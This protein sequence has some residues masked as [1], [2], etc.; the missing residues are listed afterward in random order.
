MSDQLGIIVDGHEDIASNWVNHDRHPAE[1]ALKCR[2]REMGTPI[3]A[4]VGHR[5]TGLAEW[6]AGRVALIFATL[7]VLPERHS[8]SPGI[9][10]AYSSPEE[11]E[12]KASIQLDKYRRLVDEEATFRLIATAGDLDEVLESW[13][14]PNASDALVGLVILMEGA[15]PIRQ[16]ADVESWYERGLRIVG[17]AWASTRYAGGS[18]EP[19]PL[20]PL[21]LE[22]LDHMAR[23]NMILDLSHASERA[24]LEALST[25]PSPVIASHSNPRAFRPGDR[26]LSDEMIGLLA[27][28]DGVM[29]IVPFNLFLT[30]EWQMGDPK[31]HVSVRRVAQA[32]D[33]VAQLT[34][35]SAHVALGTD[36]DGGFGAQS[37]PAEMDT[38]ADL[39]LIADELDLMGYTADDVARILSGNWLRVLRRGLE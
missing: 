9:P 20:T 33:Y 38:V 39:Y 13:R 7:F 2:D 29:G 23:L 35:S 16:P 3:P 31:G 5:T 36:F 8:P 14:S 11:A 10:V 22:L 28:R 21:G 27:E 30:P 17:L 19:G 34:G 24:F 25:Y 18:W 37:I 4:A 15:D 32:I 26:Q 1:S 12:R 6:L